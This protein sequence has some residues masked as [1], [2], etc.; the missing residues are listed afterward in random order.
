MKAT[1]H[2]F[3]LVAY[4]PIPKFLN[5]P[6]AVQS[7][8]SVCVYHF[9]VSVVM[10]NLKMAE[11]RGEVMSDPNSDLR[12][13]HTPLVAWIADYPEQLLI[14]GVSSRNSPISTATAEHFGNSEP[15]PPRLRQQTLD[16]IRAACNVCD[17]CDI[18]AFHKVYLMHRLNGVV[19]PFWA[20]WGDACP[21]SF[22]TPDALHQWHKFFF[23]HCVQ[24]VINMIGGAELDRRL[25]VLQPRTGTRRWPNGISTAK[26][27]GGKEHRDLERLLPAV[28]A[29]AIHP[30][31]LRA[32]RAI[33]EFIFVA[34]RAYH[35]EETLHSLSEA[36]REFHYYKQ[37]IIEAGGRRGK[38]GP[39]NHFHIPK[40]ELAQHVMRSTRAMGVPYQWTSD[41]MERCHI[42]HV[43]T[44]F[45][46]SNHHNFHEQCY[47]FLD[48][49]EKQRFFHL[50]TSLK[51]T[52]TALIDELVYEERLIGGSPWCH[53]PTDEQP[54]AI[55]GSS[56]SLFENPRC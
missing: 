54:T 27:T 56:K 12:V 40:L 32:L 47:R 34:Q 5:V 30:N 46:L 55:P 9:A 35:D 52:H 2:A 38:N 53:V 18:A 11:H 16:A 13:V 21:S 50:Y 24:W 8:L 15:S 6:P 10:Q 25:S 49:Q 42:T 23:D 51:L 43:K 22:L 3:A 31:V 26:Q 36:L 17:P 7:V 41:I 44:P 20:D 1:S 4:L 45:R 39:L 37:S 33:T 29:G 28:A 19:T 14:A 48:R